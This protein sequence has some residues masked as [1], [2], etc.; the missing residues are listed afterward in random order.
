MEGEP[1]IEKDGSMGISLRYLR[2]VRD[3]GLLDP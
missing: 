3:G 1:G 2:E